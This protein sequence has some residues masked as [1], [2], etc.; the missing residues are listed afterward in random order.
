MRLGRITV[1][2]ESFVAL[3]DAGLTVPQ[4]KSLAVPYVGDDGMIIKAQIQTRSGQPMWTINSYTGMDW[5][6]G[7]GRSV[8]CRMSY[9]VCRS[10]VCTD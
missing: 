9:V 4:M 7:T 6:S 3:K 2:G 10:I 8:V 5:H 1:D